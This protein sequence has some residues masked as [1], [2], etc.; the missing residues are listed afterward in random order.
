MT[1]KEL[2]AK[3]QAGEAVFGTM[4]GQTRS[5]NVVQ[6]LK[7]VGMDFLLLDTEHGPFNMESVS[8]LSRTAR[9][10]G[11]PLIVRVPGHTSDYVSRTLDIG[12]D[13][14]MAPQVHTAEQAAQVIRWAKYQPVG[15]RGLALGGPAS[16]YQAHGSAEEIMRDRNE[17][18]FIIIQIESRQAVA[19]LEGICAVPGIDV[20]LIGP[21]DFSAS[22]GKP[23]QFEDPEIVR[24]MVKVVEAGKQ[25]GIASGIHVPTVELC[26]AW[27]DR[28]MTFL[29]CT[30]EAGM[31]MTEGAR[32]VQ[33]FRSD[34]RPA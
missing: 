32:I 8:T 34:E 10:A 15:Q 23:G 19:N 27:R 31:I 12:A 22:H 21:M 6:M 26:R 13:G 24:E 28:G 25:H 29:T 20:L 2:K 7:A 9:G 17:D 4:I 5:P 18:T 1:G 3:L 11:I 33:A 30:S 14:I 16:D